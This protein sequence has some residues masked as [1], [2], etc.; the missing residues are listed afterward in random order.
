MA[1]VLKGHRI[2]DSN[3]RTLIKYVFLSDGTAVANATLVDASS[4]QFALNTSGL[5]M[6]SNV[7]PRSTYNTTIKRI[8]GSA[9]ANSYV[10]LQWEGASNTEIVTFGNGTFDYDFQSM[11]DGAI[12]PNNETNPTGDILFTINGNKMNDSF[13][14]FID[15]KKDNNDYDA[16][17][18][19]DPYAFNRKGPFP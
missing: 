1:N 5:I 11:G 15:L 16:G 4:L 7:N 13:T 9:K 8:F 10:A 17:Q 14:L 2:I 12:I 18:T 19:A 3:K 6:S